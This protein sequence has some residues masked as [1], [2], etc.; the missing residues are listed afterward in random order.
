[1]NHKIVAGLLLFVLVV[2]GCST[3]RDGLLY[4]AYHNTHA[5]YNGFFYAKEAMAEAE[6]ILTEDYKENWDEILPIFPPV[7]ETTA[8]QVYPLMERAIEKC[9]N[10][11]D[12]HTMSPS[13][14][15]QKDMKR[16]ELNKWIDDNYDII[17]RAHLIKGEKEKALEIFQYLVRTLDYPDAQ[18]WSNAW[19]A[20][21]Y[22]AMDDRVRA[23]NTL[24]KAAQI[25]RVE[26]PAVR[27]Y[28]YQVYADF[29]LKNG[30]VEAAIGMLEKAL[31]YIE[32]EKDSARTLF[33]L[34]Q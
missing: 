6:V 14:R 5:K 27:A 26:D 19:M 17:A 13:R 32:K 8:Q 28:V 23:N 2:S 11:V 33:I 3:T 12:K 1:M 15:D 20:R 4:R 22:M 31:K 24:I 18:A 25:N 16:P 7:D 9:T 30:D 29:H 21:T 10:V 34:A